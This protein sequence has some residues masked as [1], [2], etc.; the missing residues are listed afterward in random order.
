MPKSPY[1]SH[2]AISTDECEMTTG[3]EI[4]SMRPPRYA[5]LG[6]ENNCCWAFS[7]LAPLVSGGPSAPAYANVID[8]E[9]PR[10]PG[11]GPQSAGYCTE[12]MFRGDGRSCA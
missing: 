10:R 3:C 7:R 8:T 5:L 9:H 6:T 4:L 1:P 2:G 11:A 12:V